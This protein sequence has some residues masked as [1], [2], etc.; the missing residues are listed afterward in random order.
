[1]PPSARLPYMCLPLCLIRTVVAER[2]AKREMKHELKLNG[3]VW[4]VLTKYTIARLQIGEPTGYPADEAARRFLI[5]LYDSNG[6]NDP[7]VRLG[8]ELRFSGYPGAPANPI[9]HVVAPEH[10]DGFGNLAFP[11][12]MM[13]A[14]SDRV[15]VEKVE[16]KVHA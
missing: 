9:V 15:L 3:A 10:S 8:A 12:D 1:M 11:V 5:F 6:A 13:G 2:K 7:R 14:S 4:Q 16:V